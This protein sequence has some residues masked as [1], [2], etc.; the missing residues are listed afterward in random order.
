MNIKLKKIKPDIKTSL[1]VIIIVSLVTTGLMFYL[2]PGS[3]K[4]FMGFVIDS[5]S[6][7][8]LNYL[9]ILLLMLMLYFISGNCIFA[10][11]IPFMIF[12][13]AAFANRTKSTL[14]QDPLVPSDLSVITEVKSILQNYD[15][16]YMIL[17]IAAVLI[18]LAIIAL[19]FLFFKKSDK[20]TVK[21]RILGAG[22]C[23]ACFVIMFSTAYSNTELYNSYAVD[24][25][26]YFKVNQYISKGF[27]YSF[28][29][30]IN[31][32]KVEKPSSYNPEA[33]NAID[34]TAESTELNDI[35]KP[36]IVMIMSEAFSDI[37]NS[38]S[39]NFDEYGD[40][41]EFYNQF[42]NRDDVISGHIV[43][44]NFGG[45]TS[46]TEFDVLTGCST[47]Y[48]DSSQVSYN[49][50]RKPMEAMPGLLKNIGYDTLAIHPGYGW[51]YNRTN[52]YKNMG[53]DDFIYL[54]ED[55]DP[56]TQNKGG[57]ISDEVTTQSIIDNFENHVKNN[58]DPL[59]EFCVTI[60]NHGPY[61]E[62][63]ENLKTNFSTDIQLTDDE[64]A[65]YSGY[66]QGIDD[67]DA[68]IETLVNYFE[69]IDEPVVLVFFGDHLPGFS[70]GMSYFSQF[71]PDIDL[72]GNQWQQ[73]KAYE[74]PFFIWANDV[75]LKTTNFSENAKNIK[76]PVNDIISSFYLGTTV[77]ELLDMGNISPLFGFVNELRGSLPVASSNVYMYPDGT[78]SDT[79]DESKTAD[80][81][82]YKEWIYY[83][84]FD[85]E[86]STP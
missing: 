78:L 13:A 21:K 29:Y 35:S 59:F 58:D 68:Q 52:V 6:L 27:L 33:F 4:V 32:L 22:G 50:I 81:Q 24:G 1:I 40:P 73:M 37:S 2:S 75:A 18:T 83:K 55:F 79:I 57:Y 36:N 53:F 63:Y 5:P 47:K 38:E 67:A 16:I 8:I 15:K 71:R 9:P 46:D 14:R 28:I 61:E 77:M 82:K 80:I 56:S 23:I 64:K 54:E 10:S 44:P 25:N 26:I 74:T 11:G 31:N 69:S 60:Q 72:N 70:N 85:D 51:F 49:F 39:I 3:L 86:I 12:T 19:A 43:V 84:L 30:D 45:G 62:K 20:L 76:M 17:A 7:F 48:I 34:D 65:I 66:F 41:L 42:I